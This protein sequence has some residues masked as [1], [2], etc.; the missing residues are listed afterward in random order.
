MVGA[1]DP[2]CVGVR[3][4]VG[5][6]LRGELSDGHALGACGIVDLVVDVREV[7][8]EVHLVALVAQEASEQAEDHE[9]PGVA[10]VDAAVDG[11]AAGVDPDRLPGRGLAAPGA[12]RCACRGGLFSSSPGNPRASWPR[13]YPPRSRGVSR[14]RARPQRRD[15]LAAADEPDPLAGRRLH[16]HELARRSP[17]RRPAAPGSPACGARASVPASPAC[18]RR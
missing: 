17:A 13:G 15:A 16:V 12:R 11:R 6:H 3:E 8:D 2:E 9:R 1:P 7:D 4:I 5:R 10:D 14:P 18:S